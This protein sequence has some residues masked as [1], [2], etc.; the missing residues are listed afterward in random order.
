[1]WFLPSNANCYVGIDPNIN[2]HH[3]YKEQMGLYS[4]ITNSNKEVILIDKCAEDI[5]YLNIGEFDMIF[6]SPPY[7]K[8]EKYSNDS[9][10][11]SIKYRNL[12][13]WLNNFLFKTISKSLNILKENGYICINIS[14]SMQAGKVI[15]LCE[16]LLEYMTKMP[17]EYIGCL[18]MRCP[19]RSNYTADS[20]G[21]SVEPI[22]IW[23]KIN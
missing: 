23:K 17:V 22:F 20:I 9:T 2:L 14:N 3:K 21:T 15:R 16:P 1:M 13:K 4:S 11:S 10:Q 5:D 19:S 7:F 6:T 8:T 18:P 12:D